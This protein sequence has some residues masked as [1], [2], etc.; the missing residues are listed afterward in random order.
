MT[1]R[2]CWHRRAMANYEVIFESIL[3]L[4]AD[5]KP[6]SHGLLG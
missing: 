2:G 5:G 4:L 1:R 6:Y 3:G